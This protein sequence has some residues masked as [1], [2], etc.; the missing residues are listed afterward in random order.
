ML[1]Q[2]MVSI[3][4][5]YICD[6][7]QIAPVGFVTTEKKFPGSGCGDGAAHNYRADS[8]TGRAACRSVEL[9][10][11]LYDI[12][13]F[14]NQVSHFWLYLTLRL[15]CAIGQMHSTRSEKNAEVMLDTQEKDLDTS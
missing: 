7:W 9:L 5:P 13:C 12:H 6:F 1:P 2:S 10:G 8:Y 15:K 14:I 4:A 11:S 3:F